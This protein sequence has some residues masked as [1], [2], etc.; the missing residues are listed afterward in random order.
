MIA[1]SPEQ[2]SSAPP[3]ET[4]TV[5]VE[6][7]ARWT[8]AHLC[9]GS[10]PDRRPELVQVAALAI[11]ESLA[12][13]DPQAGRPLVGSA[14]WAAKTALWLHLI[15]DRPIA[16]PKHW[17]SSRHGPAAY[18]R[19]FLSADAPL[20]DGRRPASL[21]DLI[22]SSRERDPAEM[23]IE[24]VGLQQALARLHPRHRHVVIRHWLDGMTFQQIADELG[25]SRQRTEQLHAAGF[26]KLKDAL[27]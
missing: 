26:R 2:H 3:A 7:L 16:I 18:H 19:R 11:V 24:H 17:Q 8:V 1:P 12:S 4:P 5:D 14:I 9:P 22:A 21:V 27:T 20:S 15:S 6:R 10:R 23:A 13:F 25:V